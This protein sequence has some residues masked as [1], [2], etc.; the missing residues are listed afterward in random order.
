MILTGKRIG[1]TVAAAVAITG[2]GIGAAY[3]GAAITAAT[4]I[5]P[6]AA[7]ACEGGGHVVVTLLSSPSRACPAGTT[8]IV[9][10]AQGLKG[11][12]GLQ[13]IQGPPGPAGTPVTATAAVSVSNRDDSGNHGNWATD[14]FTRAVTVTRHSAAPAANCGPAAVKCWFYTAT[15]ADSGTFTTKTGASS[16]DAGT[17]IN[18]TVMGTFT[19]GS[20]IEFY[21]SSG[22]PGASAVPGTLTGDSPST[23]SW[24]K[25]FFP[26]G[27]LF[28]SPG[29]TDWSW[30]YVAPNTCE[31][32]VDAFDNSDG[33]GAGAGDITG[34]NACAA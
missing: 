16:P 15:L 9:L 2:T 5:Q 25:Q 1:L 18:G 19:G 33:T 17:V 22:T 14:A 10:G 31:K 11:A 29:L 26:D 27:T 7:Y 24:V 3:A 4:V 23:T 32:W 34:V 28:S 21:A 12:Q 13:G 8:S 6:K 30:T 20:D